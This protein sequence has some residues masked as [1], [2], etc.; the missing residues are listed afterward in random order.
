MS[1]GDPTAGV[2]P[3]YG[4][5]GVYGHVYDPWIT[6][7]SITLAPVKAY[8]TEVQIEGKFG[9]GFNPTWARNARVMLPIWD[10]VQDNPGDPLVFRLCVDVS[11]E[12]LS[13]IFEQAR[14]VHGGMGGPFN[15]IVTSKYGD[16]ALARES[17]NDCALTFIDRGRPG[18]IEIELFALRVVRTFYG[19][20]GK[21]I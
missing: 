10:V 2:G 18:L 20:N 19:A 16:A 3:G 6:D 7:P 13:D 14:L 4:M 17:F 9:H 12:S 1:Y 8:T 15:V 21:V 5:Y 11:G